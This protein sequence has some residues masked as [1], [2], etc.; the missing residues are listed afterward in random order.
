MDW[1]VKKWWKLNVS[2]NLYENMIEGTDLL[3]GED[4]NAFRAS[5]KFTSF[6][7]LPKDWTIQ[8]SGQYRAPFMDLQT[9]M[10]ASYWADLA[11]KKDILDKRATVNLRIGDVFCTGGFGHNTENE[12]MYR[13][14][15]SKRM[16]PSISLGFTYKINNGLKT[17][18]KAMMDSDDEGGDGE[19]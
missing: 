18:K 16:S 1:Q 19:Y 17:P 4:R 11:V 13:Y 15:R 12:Q 14:A 8:F 5:G 9:D 3:N 2:I 7:N 10:L 6:M